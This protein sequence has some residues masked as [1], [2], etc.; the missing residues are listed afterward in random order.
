MFASGIRTGRICRRVTVFSILIRPACH[1][2]FKGI[3]RRTVKVDL[4]V[5]AAG[6]PNPSRIIRGNI[7]KVLIR[8]GGSRTL[9]S[10]VLRLCRYR[11]LEASLT[12]TKQIHTRG[13]FSH[14]VVLEGRLSSVS[15][16]A[17]EW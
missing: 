5:V 12:Q 9:D 8:I 4:P 16:V 7:S 11:R 10:T 3:L 1:R 15:V 6:I 13:C 17:G 2:K 14:P